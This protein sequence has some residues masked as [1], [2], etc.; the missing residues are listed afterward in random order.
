MAGWTKAKRVA[1]E[2]AFYTFLDSCFINSKD[3]GQICLGENLFDGQIRFYNAV[4]GA[5]ERDVHRIYVLKSRQ[6]GISTASRALS[7]FYLGMHKGMVGA[8]VFDTA[9]NKDNA[10]AELETLINDLPS[11]LKFPAIKGGSGNREGLTLTTNAKILFKSAGVKKSKSSGTLGRSVGLSFHHSSELCSWDNDEGLESFEQSLSEVNPDRL[12]I[13]EST[14]RGFNRWWEMWKEAKND[15]GHCCTV[16]LG[17]WSKPSQSIAQDDPDFQRYGIYEP[18]EKEQHKIDEVWERY[19]HK[20]TPE[21][22]AWI[23]RKM[24]PAAQAQGDATPDF[25]GNTTRIQEQPWTED[26]AF[27]QTGSVFFAAENLTNL[28]NSHVSQNYKTYMFTPGVEFIDMMVHKAPNAKMVELKVWEEPDMD[29]IYVMGIDPAFGEN[30]TNCRSSIFIGRC[31]A[32]GIDQVAEY[33]WPL[34]TTEQFGWVIA[35]LL[36]WYG[37]GRAEIRYILELNGPGTAVF[38]SLKSLKNQLEQGYNRAAVEE[39]G[40]KNIF[41]NVRTYIYSRPDSMGAGANMHFKTTTQLK[42]TFMNQL[43]DFV[44]NGMLHI[45]SLDLVEEMKT[46]AQEGD[47]IKAPGSMKDDRVVAAALAVHYWAGS[48]R[49]NLIQKRITRA[50]EEARSRLTIVDQVALFNQNNLSQFFQQKQ[51]TRM[52]EHRVAQRIRWRGR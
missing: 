35:S 33:A 47:S 38:Q 17:W 9:S 24:D 10:R 25:E 45:R 28:T 12:Y 3:A 30:E 15:S 6:L 31:Y 49:R 42:V 23:R 39:K 16:F 21:Q 32:D 14:A 37:F 27:Q 22:L 4:F 48:I 26:D 8:L 2:K 7:A 46:I 13:Y 1:F 36:G 50:S 5:L 18:T 19:Q 20:I 41:Q 34:V 44:S 51:R 29:A 11:K 52:S 43:R 40:L